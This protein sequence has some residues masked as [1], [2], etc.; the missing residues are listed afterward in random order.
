MAVENL[1]PELNQIK[2]ADQ[3]EQGQRILA[4]MIASAYLR[5]KKTRHA[6][7]QVDCITKAME[8]KK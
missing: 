7:S 5:T 8:A 1:K 4:N 6:A 3:M 2:P